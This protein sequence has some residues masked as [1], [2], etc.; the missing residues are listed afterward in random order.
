MDYPLLHLLLNQ[1]E[2]YELQ[3]PAPS[4]GG[5]EAR[6]AG[7]ALW[8]NE[9]FTPRQRQ[10]AVAR[11]DA[12]NESDEVRIGMFNAILY[13]YGRVYSRLALEETSLVSFDDF[14]Y[15]ATTH[16]Y[17]P[18]SKTDLIQRN[19]HEK[20]TGIDIIKRLVAS[21]LLR[22]DAHPHDRR[23]K[24]LSLT[25]AGRN[26][27]FRLYPRMDQVAQMVAGNLTPDERHQLVTLLLKLDTFHNPIFLAPRPSSFEALAT[28]FFPHLP[29]PTAALVNPRTTGPIADPPNQA[30]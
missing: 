24:L 26:L 18:L 25:D 4:G 21:G 17:G 28:Q 6:L 5:D 14:V 9:Q 13:R 22:E 30:S 19:I 3:T 10:D 11:P 8:L 15:L 23:S 16:G 29:H 2:A 27:L 7:F 12:P 20:A 1:L